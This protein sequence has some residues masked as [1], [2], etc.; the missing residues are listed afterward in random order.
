MI[1]SYYKEL[2]TGCDI[3]AFVEKQASRVEL[4]VETEGGN[5]IQ[6]VELG[7]DRE[8]AILLKAGNHASEIAGIHALLTLLVERFDSP[9]KVYVIPCGNP[10]DF[11]G[12]RYALKY[13]SGE[14][15]DIRTDSDCLEALQRLGHKVFEGEHFMLF[16]VGEIVF[17]YVDRK[18]LDPRSL[19]Y[20]NL[21]ELARKDF[22]LR[23]ELSGRRI[24]FP[25]VI[26]YQEDYGSYDHAGLAAWTS[27]DGYVSN[28]NRLYD[29]YDVP[30][31]L[32]SIREFCERVR[33]AMVIDL[34]ESCI[35]TR[36]PQKLRESGEE[37]GSHF[38][39]LPSEH[40]A[41]IEGIE[42][43]VADAMIA[44]TEAANF[45]CFSRSQLE[46]AWGYPES[47]YFHGYVRKDVRLGMPFY[48]WATRFAEVSITNETSMDRPIEER[49]S[50]HTALVRAALEAFQKELES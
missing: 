43:R 11:G 4:L 32:S 29:R 36:I 50:I 30:V 46:A 26:Y 13:A 38:L 34:H 1:M 6:V 42:A 10:F 45:R 37:L 41:S 24:F 8:P 18:Q 15:L 33:P 16:R 39:I 40:I 27:R 7:G 20:G 22:H 28:L 31:E 2:K 5:P 12:Y 25:N 47:E 17:A 23:F 14:V 49:V 35:N 19:F 44:G 3:A 21:D 48:C 9:F